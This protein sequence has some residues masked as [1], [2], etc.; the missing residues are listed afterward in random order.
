ML[1]PQ[2]LKL[3]DFL[4]LLPPVHDLLVDQLGRGRLPSL[5]DLLETVELDQVRAIENPWDFWLLTVSLL[6][7]LRLLFLDFAKV[8]HL[9]Q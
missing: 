5:G 3:H 8:R 9:N 4:R 7:S 6:L 1:P 2:V